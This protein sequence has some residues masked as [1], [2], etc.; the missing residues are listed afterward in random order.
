MRQRRRGRLRSICERNRRATRAATIH[1]EC[2]LLAGGVHRSPHRQTSRSDAWYSFIIIIIMY[3]VIVFYVVLTGSSKQTEKK[4]LS[5]FSSSSNWMRLFGT[6]RAR[7]DVMFR[8]VFHVLLRVT[9][10]DAKVFFLH[11]LIRFS[12][13]SFSHW[14]Y[15]HRCDRFREKLCERFRFFLQALRVAHFNLLVNL[16]VEK[17]HKDRSRHICRQNKSL[18]ID[19]VGADAWNRHAEFILRTEMVLFSGDSSSSS[20]FFFFLFVLVQ[21]IQ[22][23]F[24]YQPSSLLPGQKVRLHLAHLLFAQRTT[25][26]H[27]VPSR[28]RVFLLPRFDRVSRFLLLLFLFH[29]SFSLLLLFFPFNYRHVLLRERS[30]AYAS[31]FFM[32]LPV[33]RLCSQLLL[34]LLLLLR[35][36]HSSFQTFVFCISLCRIFCSS[37]KY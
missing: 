33:V 21:K 17:F 35:R 8:R 2:G 31:S 22:R 10:N 12:G 19:D 30:I 5:F 28:I 14:Q 27:H 7:P 26:F 11:F 29:F 32:F 36:L 3:Y 18:R 15:R 34:L 16:L 25:R 20:F 6:S 1:G 4:S 13:N 9:S 23:V 24:R 37:W